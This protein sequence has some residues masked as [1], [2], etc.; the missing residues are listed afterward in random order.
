MTSVQTVRTD[1]GRKPFGSLASRAAL[2]LPVLLLA[3]LYAVWPLDHLMSMGLMLPALGSIE[4]LAQTGSWLHC[5]LTSLGERHAM[6][7]GIP[8]TASASLIRRATPVELLTAWN[9][10]GL[11]ALYLAG[12][13]TQGFL[14]AMDVDSR[15]AVAA[16]MLFLSLPVVFAKEGYPLML[17][18]FALMPAM[19]WVQLAS[20]RWRSHL[21][22]FSAM[23]A[24]LT[25]GLFQEPYSTVMALTFGGW[26]A[27]IY[28]ITAVRGRRLRAAI[29][30][31]LWLAAALVAMFA[32]RLYIP[33]GANYPV[34]PLDYFRGQGIDLI[35][36]LARNPN[37]YAV[38]PL[39]GIG[40][41]DPVMFF[42][43]GEMTAHSY[44]GLGLLLGLL[45]FCVV[46][47]PWRR[48]RHLA[49]LITFASA[50]VM[51]LGPSLKI[52]STAEGRHPDDPITFDTYL[53]P[54]DAAVL[55]MPHAFVYK[56]MP[57]SNMRSVSRWY[58]LVAIALVV[59]LSLVIQWLARRG[60]LGIV[61]SV[62]LAGWVALEYWPNVER[63]YALGS[64]FGKAY[65][66]MEKML[67]PELSA[68][69]ESNERVV[70][71]AGERYGNEYFST[72][73]CAQ[74]G[75]RTFNV[76]GDKPRRNAL[77]GWLEPMQKKLTR[78]AS[79]SE[80]AALLEE[81]WFDVLVVP[82][83][84]MR[85][86]SYRW[87]PSEAQQSKMQAWAEAYGKLD[88]FVVET[89]DWF[90]TVRLGKTSAAAA[91]V[92]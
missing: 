36:L 66:S 13:C 60:R 32:Y 17:W 59:M 29:R 74:V 56:V 58:L 55:T 30:A 12:L 21:A 48:V 73:L 63:R 82:H 79:A 81:G 28:Q 40:S 72:Y 69:I 44:L 9:L 39:W 71:I 6:P 46:L 75:C 83:F 27:I 33:G 23:A 34:M 52:D 47:K 25:L 61:A 5:P 1:T 54:A 51:A 50:F 26:L 86:D 53:M 41:L 57:F 68:M 90:T 76:S 24:V 42:T 38:G 43:D 89:G 7:Y 31:L 3:P 85:W 8:L 80:R 16:S 88:G 64:A 91:E 65:Q 78:P 49:L 11:L 35:A 10:A 84:H 15:L 92:R 87:P 18:G 22:A 67:I 45:L 37:L 20:R 14:R 4:C 70:F 2:A 62:L 19:L 77:S